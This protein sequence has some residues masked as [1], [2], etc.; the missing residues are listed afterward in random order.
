MHDIIVEAR[1]LGEAPNA[2][3]LRLLLSEFIEVGLGEFGGLSDLLA[4]HLF[5]PHE[6]R[7]ARAR[8]RRGT[9]LLEEKR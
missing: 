9:L 3:P 5:H 6:P 7:E 8:F 1:C 2:S 4:G